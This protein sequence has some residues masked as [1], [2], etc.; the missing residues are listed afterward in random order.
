MDCERYE[1]MLAAYASGDLTADEAEAVERHL[2]GCSA[3]RQ[4]LE[5]YRAVIGLIA[6]EPVVSPTASESAAMA[7][8]VASVEP[9]RQRRVDRTA[10]PAKGLPGFALATLAAFV[11]I[12]LV[13]GLQA[14]G[15][16]DIVWLISF[17]NPVWIA[18]AAVLVVF[19]SS[20]IPIWITA[21]RRPLNG[22]TFMR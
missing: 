19:V 21:R 15:S 7:S 20:F 10:V 8:A 16:I 11:L 3:C 6:D 22:L 13:L 9:G 12:A 5:G 4:T 17:V 1:Q 2:S 14:F 18:V